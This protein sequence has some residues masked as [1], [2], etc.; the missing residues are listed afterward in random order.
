LYLYLRVERFILTVLVAKCFRLGQY[1]TLSNCMPANKRAKG[2]STIH[3][4]LFF[5]L[6]DG[7][8]LKLQVILVNRRIDKSVLSL[9]SDHDAV[10]GKDDKNQHSQAANDATN[11]ETNIHGLLRNIRALAEAS[12]RSQN[13]RRCK[14]LCASVLVAKTASREGFGTVEASTS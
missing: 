4:V 14:T 12:I 13:V 9:A 6:Q 10:H 3:G 1:D 8:R 11:N 7:H 5:N 2:Y